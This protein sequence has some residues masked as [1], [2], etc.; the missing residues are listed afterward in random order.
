MKHRLVNLALLLGV[1]ML[2]LVIMEM[3]ARTLP[4]ARR[5]GWNLVPLLPDRMEQVADKGNRRRMVV[6]GD[7]FAEWME[8]TGGNFV[9]VAERTMGE[10]G[11]DVQF[12]NM[13]EAGSGLADYYRNLVNYGP[14]LK[15]DTVVIAIYIGNDLIPFPGGLP[16]SDKVDHYLPVPAY[17]RSW[18]R[19]LK[20]SVLLNLVYRQAKLHLPWLRSGFTAQVV[21]YLRT[22]GGKDQAFVSQR[23]AKL[24]PQIL[25]AA[26]ADA[27]NGWDLATALFT[28]DY[29]GN[30]ADA[31]T[32]SAEGAAALAALNDLRT[33]LR[34]AKSLSA[35]PMVVLIPPSPWVAER[36]HD[37][38]RG[39]GYG[40]LG[41]TQ[42]EPVILTRVKAM[43]KEE[44]TSY[45]DLLPVL[46]ASP[47][48]AYL[49]QDIH[50]NS[51]GQ[52]L[53]GDELAHFLAKP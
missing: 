44:N 49:D 11:Q 7:S 4:E 29:Y 47:Q 39:L 23:L 24:D 16:S 31:N 33:L 48:S 53:A 26:E 46:R 41:P 13:G 12:V 17:D 19:T 15:P 37:Y 32:Q 25:H 27:I 2:G 22:R 8:A 36:Y 5:L 42:S 43:L 38:F 14:R 1:V 30:L 34:Y 6:V 9:R 10:Q 40:R 28:P 51:H 3:V 52:I 20:K 45:L 35:R 18:R 21:E 50:F